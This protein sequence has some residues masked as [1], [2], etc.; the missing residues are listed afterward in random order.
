MGLCPG[1][2]LEPLQKKIFVHQAVTVQAVIV[3]ASHLERVQRLLGRGGLGGQN[4]KLKSFTPKHVGLNMT[5]VSGQGMPV[6]QLPSQS[7]I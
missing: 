4:T 1:L 2:R 5:I 3:F 7:L 6:T